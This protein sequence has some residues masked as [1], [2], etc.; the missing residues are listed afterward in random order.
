MPFFGLGNHKNMSNEEV[1]LLIAK[2]FNS[3]G[4]TFPTTFEHRVD[5]DSSA[6]MYSM[7][8]HFKPV[9]ALSIGTWLGGS[10]CVIMAALIKNDKRFR[11]FASELLDDMR[12]NTK[13]HCIEKNGQAPTMIADITKNLSMLPR[14]IDFLFHDSDHDRET[15][16]WVVKN[17]FPKLKDGAL[18]IFHDWAV[19]EEGDKW[20]GKGENG[21]GG[22][23]E[24]E[25]L[26]ELHRE[27]KLPL[28][29]VY[30]N[31]RNPENHELGVFKYKK[32]K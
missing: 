7:I 2:Y 21:I 3:E 23:P 6:V 27:G 9:S 5:E 11:Y 1:N 10:V 26:L 32:Q 19:Y 18:V 30:W 25:Y 24:T 28:E 31:Y 22:W 12:E 20:L 13:K 29:K 17:V 15:T 4:Y 16:Q 14:K 8:R